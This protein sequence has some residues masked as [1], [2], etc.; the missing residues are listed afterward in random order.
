[1]MKSYLLL[2][3]ACLAWMPGLQAQTA[4]SMV[5]VGR[6]LMTT[7]NL[8]AADAAFAQALTSQPTHQ[9]AN[10][11]RAATRLLALPFKPAGS[12]FLT[13]IG[14]PTTG[15]EWLR[16][17]AKLPTDTNG[18][19]L[20]PAGVSAT[21][22]FQQA[23]T[24]ILPEISAALANL[25]AITSQSFLLNLSSNETK[26]DDCTLDYGDF[27][28]IRS[29]LHTMQCL[30]YTLAEQNMDVQLSAIRA[31]YDQ[32]NLS[33]Q[34]LLELDGRLLTHTATNELPLARQ[35]FVNAANRYQEASVWIRARPSGVTRLFNWDTNQTD[36]EVQFR[37]T[38]E[39]FQA[40]LNG[41][42]VVR[43]D[44]RFEVSL[45]PLF[46]GRIS[47]RSL[48]PEFYQGEVVLDTLPDRTFGGSI[49]GL[50]DQQ[51]N[52]S[53][54]GVYRMGT[55]TNQVRMHN[56]VLEIPVNGAKGRAYVIMGTTDFKTW[57]TVSA[58]FGMDEKITTHD[59]GTA[60]NRSRF[61]KVI[62]MSASSAAP[63]MP[64]PSNS[65]FSTRHA[66]T[67]TDKDYFGWCVNGSAWW[68]WTAPAAGKYALRLDAVDGA[69]DAAVYRG[70]ST[71]N[72]IGYS[73][74]VFDA[75]QGEV[76][77]V[78]VFRWTTSGYG[79]G[80]KLRMAP[81]VALSAGS[82]PPS[83][84]TLKAPATISLDI[85]ATGAV[86]TKRIWVKDDKKVLGLS[87][88]NRLTLT[89]TNLPPSNYYG[90]E[91]KALDNQGHLISEP[92]YYFINP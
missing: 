40:S 76:F 14:F 74:T 66:M 80:L 87:A 71:D 5:A 28:L 35:A 7:S 38:L 32:D 24:N 8:Y 46:D 69:T 3:S 52:R 9:E 67:E 2:L 11:L 47:W 54:G 29:V 91:V 77:Q 10:A 90:L 27:L 22:L 58:V 56:G 13:R 81:T 6:S 30:I 92:L 39:D 44:P 21:E 50:S 65:V 17:S 43:M 36:A 49:L 60:T 88:S 26:L 34:T 85:Q 61:Y 23:R 45:A 62:E 72:R 15:R 83:G 57:T 78:E 1:M 84:S 75:A 18:A 86:G 4:D 25:E 48:L 55:G 63:F 51:I 64:A 12:N 37:Q 53:M 42:S 70:A 79:G 33:P 89:L 19:P 16:W 82:T 59:W 20:A 68:T 73:G 31:L 41:P